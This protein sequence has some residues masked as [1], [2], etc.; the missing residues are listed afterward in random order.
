MMS[1]MYVASGTVLSNTCSNSIDYHLLTNFTSN[2]KQASKQTS[3]VN[4]ITRFILGCWL[5]CLQD[6]D[7]C[8]L[9]QRMVW[10][11]RAFQA[12]QYLHGKR[13]VHRDLK[14]SNLLLTDA[15]VAKVGP[16][17]RSW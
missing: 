6:N 9:L 3:F 16:D 13:V 2:Y 1:T 4:N 11:L 5:Q 8:D 10:G 14:L 7:P 15:Y 17:D 12:V